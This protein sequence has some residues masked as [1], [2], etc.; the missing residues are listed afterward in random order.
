MANDQT[1]PQNEVM[2]GDEAAVFL[3]MP[4]STLLKLCSEGQLPG[5]KVGR[6]WRFNRFALENWMRE[7][8]G[9]A[10]NL[11][12]ESVGEPAE[13][14]FP[15]KLQKAESTVARQ[16]KPVVEEMV[17]SVGDD[18]FDS[19]GEVREIDEFSG[20]SEVIEQPDEEEAPAKPTAKAARK[21]PARST[22][23]LELMA[24]ISEKSQSKK[25]SKAAPAPREPKI[26]KAVQPSASALPAF[27]ETNRETSHDTDAV[28]I[29]RPYNKPGAVPVPPSRNGDRSGGGMNAFRKL[30][31]WVVILVVLGAAGFGIKELLNPGEPAPSPLAQPKPQPTMPVLPEFQVVYKHND[32]EEPIAAQANISASAPM[33]AAVT[34][35]ISTPAPTPMPAPVALV[36][37]PTPKPVTLTPEVPAPRTAPIAQVAAAPAPDQNLEA[38]NRLLPS[39]MEL[40]G[41]VIT[42]NKN[43]IRIKFEE[44]I[45]ASGLK[46]DKKGREQ[47]ALT[48]ALIAKNAPDFWLI[49]EGQTDGTAM[50]QQSP[51][52]DNY[53]LGLRRAVAATE[54]LREDS[55]FPAER[56]LVSSTG[57]MTQPFSSDVPN[58]AARNRTVIL[59]LVPKTGPVPPSIQ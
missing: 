20:V 1:T 22:S 57:G 31:Y 29:S 24:Q 45:F 37:A 50:R 53:T 48:G 41:C 23:A 18:D 59:R 28:E 11:P 21:T 58:A 55:N 2:N 7:R 54:V 5:V 4:K 52:R 30:A 6:Q 27:R 39:L 47:L 43:E 12:E 38:I 9:E 46:V 35:A 25:S 3:K 40:P 32:N 14:D 36:E 17:G 15:A 44:G 42:S 13:I 51:F 26:R 34:E 10:T 56:L 19:V 33:P 16:I 8:D 49:I